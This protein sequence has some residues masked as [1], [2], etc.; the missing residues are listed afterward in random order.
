MTS[1]QVLD[2]GLESKPERDKKIFFPPVL[3]VIKSFLRD[4]SGSQLFPKIL[5]GS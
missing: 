2:I 1:L 3:N 5:E 4:K